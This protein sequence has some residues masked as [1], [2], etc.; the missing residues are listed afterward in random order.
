MGP[1]KLGEAKRAAHA[2]ALG[3]LLGWLL[4]RIGRA[5]LPRSL[6]GR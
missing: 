4:A 3:V 6:G 1:T 2:I 5:D